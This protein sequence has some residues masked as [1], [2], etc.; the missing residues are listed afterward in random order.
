[1][2]SEDIRVLEDR[3]EVAIAEQIEGNTRRKAGPKCRES[4]P[5]K[6]ELYDTTH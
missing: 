6:A 3:E 4:Q 2:E 1:M 5:H